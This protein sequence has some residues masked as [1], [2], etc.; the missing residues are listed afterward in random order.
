MTR[1]NSVVRVAFHGLVAVC[2]SAILSVTVTA[3]PGPS[4]NP[5]LPLPSVAVT[6]PIV[7]TPPV[8]DPAHGYPY[9]ATPMDLAK[10]GYVEEEFFIEGQANAYNTPPGQTGSV[11]DTGHPFKTRIVVRRPRSASS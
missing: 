7:L 5:S 2:L 8:R 11:K 10:H 3:L 1:D 9:N 6:G 4:S